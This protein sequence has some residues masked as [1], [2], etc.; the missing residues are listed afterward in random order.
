MTLAHVREL[1]GVLDALAASLKPGGWV[2]CLEPIQQ[3][4]RFCELHPPCPSLEFLMDRLRLVVLERGS[5]MAVALKIAHGLERRGLEDIVLRDYGK[6]LHGADAPLCI[7]EVLLPLARAYLR[8]RLDPAELERRLGESLGE[9]STPHLW[10][11][12]RRAV[13]LGRRPA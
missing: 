5:D 9:A 8:D 12:F 10:L 11:D 13:V 7:R 1:D 6:A 2:A 4:R 3:N